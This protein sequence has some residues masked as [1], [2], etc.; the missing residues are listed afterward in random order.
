MADFNFFSADILY[1]VLSVAPVAKKL[2]WELN[3]SWISE[4]V[5]WGSPLI[6]VISDGFRWSLAHCMVE[7]LQL[8]RIHE[9]RNR[10]ER[11][12]LSVCVA[13]KFRNILSLDAGKGASE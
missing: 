6:H 1:S 12:A 11:V 4:L 8:L 2:R 7:M 9:H 3:S 13:G 10:V 5:M